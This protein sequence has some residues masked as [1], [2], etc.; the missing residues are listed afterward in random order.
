MSKI[1]EFF[2]KV[3]GGARKFFSKADSTIEGGLKKAGG[4]ARQIGNI[5]S[6]A[7]PLAA[8]VAPELAP[9]IA[10]A[11]IGSNAAKVGIDRA[12]QVQKSVR[13]GV[14]DVKRTIQAPLPPLDVGAFNPPPM[15]VTGAQQA[16]S[17]APYAANFA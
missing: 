3:G 15:M 8:V 7:L 4:V 9:A 6:Q 2:K 12:R 1:R 17:A 16:P 10:L 14:A 5:A 11:G 13:R